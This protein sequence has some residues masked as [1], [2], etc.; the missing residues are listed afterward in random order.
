M[1]SQISEPSPVFEVKSVKVSVTMSADM[2]AALKVAGFQRRSLGESNAGISCLVREA[3]EEWL[4]REIDS[5][6]LISVQ[7]Q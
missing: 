6:T 4:N 3:V 7:I 2:V 5:A 1:R